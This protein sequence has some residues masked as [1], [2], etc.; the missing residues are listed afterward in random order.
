MQSKL[1]AKLWNRKFGR[2]LFT[3]FLV[4]QILFG[5]LGVL[6][7]NVAQAAVL[8]DPI[9]TNS[10]IQV[11]EYKGVDQSIKD[12]LCVPDDNNLGNALVS[13]IGKVYRFGIAFGAIALVFFIVLAGYLYIA[14]GETSK[15]KGKLMFT[16]SLTGM[17]II[18]S[19]YVLLRFINPDLTAIKPIQTPI[20]T[21]A[22]LPKCEDVGYQ[23]NC[24]LPSGQ[25]QTSGG[26]T[27]GSAAEAQYKDLIAKYAAAEGIEYC[28][29]SALIEKESSWIYNN[30]S[31]PPPSRVDV[32]AGPPNY[33]ITTTAHGIGLTQIYIFSGFTRDG[34]EFGFNRPLTIQDMITPDTSIK[35]GAHLWATDLK[36]SG[37]D[38]AAA[39]YKYQGPKSAPATITALLGMYNLCKLRK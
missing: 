26:G 1:V 34:G 12:Y 31:N 28:Q 23:G 13:C 19:S 30:V 4:M 39:Y 35:A 17:L 6:Q 29:L 25:I 7:A 9:N 20:F 24:V 16:T 5:Y 37:N 22:N 27:P 11:P 8:P 21:A 10:G 38:M 32:N 14:G 2:K 3:G 15:Q 18:L 33:N 36:K